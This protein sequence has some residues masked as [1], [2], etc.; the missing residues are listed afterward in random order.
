MSG[1]T[2]ASHAGIAKIGGLPVALPATGNLFNDAH[3]HGTSARARRIGRFNACKDALAHRPTANIHSQDRPLSGNGQGFDVASAGSEVF[4]D[5]GRCDSAPA[6]TELQGESAGSGQEQ[7]GPVAVRFFQLRPHGV[8]QRLR[9]GD[10]LPRACY[11]LVVGAF[12]GHQDRDGA[13][14]GAGHR[15]RPAH[16]H[17]PTPAP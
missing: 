14:L 4:V 7:V 5:G 15:R 13:A 17:R 16:L 6:V 9:M 2:A 8:T 11:R 10:G 1:I 12:G 3:A